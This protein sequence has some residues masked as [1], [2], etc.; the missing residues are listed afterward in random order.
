M[1]LDQ[2]DIAMM[3]L[4]SPMQTG[5]FDEAYYH[6]D[7]DSRTKWRISIDKK[8][9]VMNVHRVWKQINKSEMHDGF[10]CVKS[11]WVFKIKRNSVYRA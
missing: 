2:A 8:F 9:K 6:S 10:L 1:I 3:M 11:K 4:E 5:N 7:L